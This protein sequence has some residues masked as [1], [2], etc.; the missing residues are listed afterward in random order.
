MNT[1]DSRQDTDQPATPRTAV[2]VRMSRRDQQ[3]S[4]DAQID[5]IREF[6]VRSG[7][8]FVMI[9]PDKRKSGFCQ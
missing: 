9:H 4:L 2:Y 7:L 1:P 8:E 5:L 6:A 3:Y